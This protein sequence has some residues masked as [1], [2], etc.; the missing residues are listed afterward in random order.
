MDLNILI[1]TVYKPIF[2]EIENKG[3][4][5]NEKQ[6]INWWNS[7]KDG[8][9]YTERDISSYKKSKVLAGIE[10]LSDAC[11][12][13]CKTLNGKIFKMTDSIP[14]IPFTECSNLRTG[15]SCNCCFLPVVD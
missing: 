9:N 3:L 11:C 4:F 14:I 13:K 10:V 12:D 8:L 6:K 5:K 15:K 1:E 7:V 2:N